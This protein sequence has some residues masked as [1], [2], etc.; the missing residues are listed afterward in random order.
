MSNPPSPPIECY[1]QTTPWNVYTH[2]TARSLWMLIYF[3]FCSLLQI[4]RHATVGSIWYTPPT[5]PLTHTYT[6]YSP[7]PWGGWVPNYTSRVLT[8]L[9]LLSPDF[10]QRRIFG[11]WE[12]EDISNCFCASVHRKP[13]SQWLYVGK[14]DNGW[15]PFWCNPPLK[16]VV[17]GSV[18]TWVAFILQ[19]VWLVQ[20]L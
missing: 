18:N 6:H 5:L 15:S 10:P 17:W 8:L 9:C 3:M 7:S 1:G 4:G 14:A 13:I 11:R 19:C 2:G 20:F 16:A 12:S